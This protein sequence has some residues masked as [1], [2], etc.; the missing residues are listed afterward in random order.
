MTEGGS[1]R[2]RLAPIRWLRRVMELSASLDEPGLVTKRMRELRAA[3]TRGWRDMV[4]AERSSLLAARE[5]QAARYVNRLLTADATDRSVLAWIIRDAFS[6]P[7]AAT[8]AEAVL[9]DLTASERSEAQ[10]LVRER[11]VRVSALIKALELERKLFGI[12]KSKRAKQQRKVRKAFARSVR[13]WSADRAALIRAYAA[14][15]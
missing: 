12:K 2:D 13:G 6:D 15:I 10:K 4:K 14:G 8:A 3:K 9:K 7:K 11:T 5:Q 1:I